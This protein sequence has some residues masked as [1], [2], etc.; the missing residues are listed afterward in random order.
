M[1]RDD[2]EDG[3]GCGLRCSLQDVYEGVNK[4]R[5]ESETLKMKVEVKESVRST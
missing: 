2:C 4:G 5:K 3:G 1:V